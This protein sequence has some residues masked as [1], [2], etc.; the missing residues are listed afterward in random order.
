[1]METMTAW[2]TAMR[3]LSSAISTHALQTASNVRI[4]V[5]SPTAGYVMGI[6]IV[7]TMKMNLIPHAQHAHV[8]PTSSPVPVVVASQTLG[9]VTWMMIVGIA[10]MNQPHVPTQLASL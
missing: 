5:A 8:L 9:P 2:T 1:M 3:H 7:A 6:M 4:T 10:L